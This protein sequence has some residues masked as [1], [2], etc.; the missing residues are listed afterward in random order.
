MTEYDEHEN[1]VD[2]DRLVDGELS[3]EEGEQVYT[4]AMM[5]CAVWTSVQAAH[6]NDQ[7]EDWLFEA[8]CEDVSVELS[9]GR[10]HAEQAH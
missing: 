9:H 1:E 5:F 3:P 6:D 2:F 10:V 8:A 4:Y 7:I